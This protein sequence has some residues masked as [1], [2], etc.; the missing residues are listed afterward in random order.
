MIPAL[1]TNP[2]SV[3]SLYISHSILPDATY[4]GKF[5]LRKC[6]TVITQIISRSVNAATRTEQS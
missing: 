6:M 2:P 4:S 5:A 3:V 1:E